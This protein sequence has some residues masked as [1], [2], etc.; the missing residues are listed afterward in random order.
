MKIKKNKNDQEFFSEFLQSIRVRV[1]SFVRISTD[2]ATQINY[3]LNKKNLTQRDLAERL[4]K[5]ESEISK[6]LSGNHN[7]TIK[8]IANIEE[9]I[10]EEIIIVPLFAKKEIK[11]IPVQSYSEQFDSFVHENLKLKPP[12]ENIEFDNNSQLLFNLTSSTNTYG[13]KTFS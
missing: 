8:T 2:I 12:M 9:A 5:K 7:F 11:F 10:G 3:F 13:T 6:W 1:K 4:G